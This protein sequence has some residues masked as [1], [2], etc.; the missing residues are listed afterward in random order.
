MKLMLVFEKEQLKKCISTF[1]ISTFLVGGF[2]GIY[3]RWEHHISDPSFEIFA[4]VAALFYITAFILYLLNRVE[5]ANAFVNLFT[6]IIFSVLTFT[7]VAYDHLFVSARD[8]DI[9]DM[10]LIGSTWVYCCG[11]LLDRIQDYSK[12]EFH[13]ITVREVLL[14]AGFLLGSVVSEHGWSIS[15]LVLAVACN[16][17][18][19]HLKSSL[20]LANAVMTSVLVAVEFF[21]AIK[22]QYNPYCLAAFA[23]WLS[24][25]GIIDMY[26]SKYSTVDRWKGFLT[27][28]KWVRK[29]MVL[30]V[31]LVEC[32]YVS[33]AIHVIWNHHRAVVMVPIFCAFLFFWFVGH[34]V[35]LVDCWGFII[36]IEECAQTLPQEFETN[37][38][39]DVLA[40]RGVRHFCLVSKFIILITMMTTVLL[41]I[42]TW[43]VANAWFIS[44]FL[45]VMPIESM[46]YSVLSSLGKCLGGTAIGYA[47]VIPSFNYKMPGLVVA[48]PET[49]YQGANQVAMEMINLL[50]RFFSE[51][52]V[53]SFG[54]ELSTSGI[55]IQSL[56]S[57]LQ[58][59]FNQCVLPG[60]S[61][62]TYLLYYSGPVHDNGDWA[63]MENNAFSLM[64]LLN[65]W[66]KTNASKG[67][68]LMLILDTEN[69]YKWLPEVKKSKF[70]V[71][72]QVGIPGKPK[73]V[74]AGKAQIVGE[75][76][77]HW[78]NVNSPNHCLESLA[79]IAT[80]KESRVQP[81]YGV[82]K[83]WC[84][85]K[86]HVPSQKDFSLHIESF[87]AM[88]QPIMRFFNMFPEMNN[89]FCCCE[90]S[91]AMVK[92]LKM[93]WLP[94]LMLDTGHGFKLMS[95]IHNQ[96]MSIM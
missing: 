62:D 70:F 5:L 36:K 51:H 57:K 66:E 60:L 32:V 1:A 38:M 12:V 73:D 49:I 52:V 64:Q 53:H 63:L 37:T 61:Y 84:S 89:L 6:G 90:R 33:F 59:F 26:F 76:T 56:E 30:I 47:I 7:S 16:L 28:G 74:E 42:P 11:T 80:A 31:L 68:R 40:S 2:L 46:V 81:A 65:N 55:T 41:A 92:N 69:S 87:P 20:S 34:L 18:A 35:L 44:A 71:G 19:V 91:V 45:I 8:L 79:R 48:I 67:A 29:F 77:K 17:V 85:F 96:E 58:A 72:M 86:F 75:L 22:V 39:L 54:T 23:V 3:S 24:F 9:V 93:R 94:P 21:P 25:E 14:L 27:C 78:V 15:L 10:F 13:L 95:T 82:S 88:V 83:N 43:Q 50:S 4:A